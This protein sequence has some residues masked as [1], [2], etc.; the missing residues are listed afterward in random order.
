MTRPR[1]PRGA[2]K[3]GD[4]AEAQVAE[5]LGWKGLLAVD[6]KPAESGADLYVFAKDPFAGWVVD[7]FAEVKARWFKHPSSLEPKA[8]R[9]LAKRAAW[10]RAKNIPYRLYYIG[11]D[12]PTQAR[13]FTVGDLAPS[14]IRNGLTLGLYEAGL[15]DLS[16][17]RSPPLKGVSEAPLPSAHLPEP[18]RD[19]IALD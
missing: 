3:K 16:P 5:A 4:K 11:D 13:I 14:A 18:P 1:S 15:L 10:A 9:A 7:H 6:G 2:K 12:R 19:L 17:P 8:K